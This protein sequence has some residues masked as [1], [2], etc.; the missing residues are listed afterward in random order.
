MFSY[1]SNRDKLHELVMCVL[2]LIS[3]S[4]LSLALFYILGNNK[5]PLQLPSGQ[6]LPMV[7]MWQPGSKEEG[8]SGI[9]AS[10]F[11]LRHQT[12]HA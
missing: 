11:C 3:V 2:P 1:E 12:G 10:L 8:G 6:I 9:F 7:R 4:C 5:G